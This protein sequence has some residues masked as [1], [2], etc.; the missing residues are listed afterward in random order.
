MVLSA[1]HLLATRANLRAAHEKLHGRQLWEDAHGSCYRCKDD[2]ANP[3]SCKDCIN[4]GGKKDM[5]R[6]K[7]RRRKLRSAAGGR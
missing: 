7:P 3:P 4:G 2:Y 6:E 1:P 5:F